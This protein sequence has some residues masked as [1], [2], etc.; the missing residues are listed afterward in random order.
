MKRR[1]NIENELYVLVKSFCPFAETRPYISRTMCKECLH[2][3]MRFEREIGIKTN[4][5][6]D[7]V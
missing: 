1:H 2:Y 5:V 4:L 7:T 3:Y 6:K